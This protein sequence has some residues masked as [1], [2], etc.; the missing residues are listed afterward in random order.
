MFRKDV[1][2]EDEVTGGKGNRSWG[3]YTF[4]G[5]S[6]IWLTFRKGASGKEETGYTTVAQ[7]SVPMFAYFPL[8]SILHNTS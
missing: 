4:N 6:E 8:K 7:I 5:C 3:Q 1:G 2:D